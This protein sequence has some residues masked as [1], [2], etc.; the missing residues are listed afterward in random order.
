MRLLTFHYSPS[1]S[2]AVFF[3]PFIPYVDWFGPPAFRGWVVDHLPFRRL[4]DIKSM[5]DTIHNQATNIFRDKKAALLAGAMVQKVGEG[6]DIMSILRKQMYFRHSQRP[7][8]SNNSQ[9]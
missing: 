7:E 9:G 3:G 2:T 1:F 5:A 4:R 6:K 8:Y